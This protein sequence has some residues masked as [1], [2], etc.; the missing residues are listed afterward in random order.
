MD[1]DAEE[2]ALLWKKSLTRSVSRADDELCSFRTCLRWMCVDQ[3]DPWRTTLCWS[4]FLVLAFGVP[5]LSHLILWCPACDPKHQRPYDLLVEVSL[6]SIST[7]S[8]LSLSSFV[9][10]YGLRRF[11]FLDKLCDESEKVRQQYSHQLNSSFRLLSCFVLPCFVVE[12][13]YK[14]W[15]YVYGTAKFPF[16]WNAYVSDTISCILELSSWVYRTSIFFLVCV[17]FQLIC[18]LQILRLQDFTKVFQAESDVETI[19]REHLRVRKQLRVISHRYRAFI[20]SSLIVVTI[21]QFASL[22][23]TT[24]STA[25]INLFK[26]GDVALCSVVLLTGLLICLRSAVK[27]THK[28]QAIVSHAAKWHICMTCD[29][30]E[31]LDCETPT[32]VSANQRVSPMSSSSATEPDSDD[33]AADEDDFDE[34]L[35]VPALA[36]AASFQKRQA[37][38]T[39]FEHNRA[40]ISVFGLML[41]RSSLHTV[42]GIELSLVLWILGKTVGIS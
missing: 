32:R 6:T 4:V 15:W 30:F 2:Q 3:S 10:K 12:I 7:L 29:S 35:I 19:L 27:I 20:I 26:A 33:E 8:F 28:A 37:L 1:A 38:V 13:G 41:D 18:H 23:A 21:S 16:I 34:D 42:F 31:T 5:I 9:R 25:H 24:R 14:A 11:L 40:G 17:L 36:S 22:L 39:Y